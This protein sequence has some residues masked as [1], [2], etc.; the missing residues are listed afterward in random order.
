MARHARRS[1]TSRAAQTCSPS[2]RLGERRLLDDL[3][4]LDPVVVD[5]A[6]LHIGHVQDIG[7]GQQLL[8][9]DLRAT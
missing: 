5:A 9:E 8:L 2:R 4:E 7:L 1:D 3:V 6:Q